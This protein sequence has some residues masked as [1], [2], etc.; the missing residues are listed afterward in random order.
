MALLHNTRWTELAPHFTAAKELGEARAA[1]VEAGLPHV[2]ERLDWALD[3]LHPCTRDPRA[4][5]EFEERM[6]GTFND[7]T[8]AP[9]P[10]APASELK[11][12]L[13]RIA[14]LERKL[15][16]PPEPTDP[17]ANG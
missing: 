14:E 7:G 9:V 5:Q 8:K 13:D 17:N 3:E 15:A 11:K 1:L 12:A 10:S 4:V 16:A 6:A 2:A